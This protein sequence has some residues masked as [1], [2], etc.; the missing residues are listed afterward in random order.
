MNNT[1]GLSGLQVVMIASVIL[2]VMLIKLS[3]YVISL[4]VKHKIAIGDD[5]NSDMRLA[6]RA[7]ANF[8][9]YTPIALILL[10]LLTF[11]DAHVEVIALLAITFIIGRLLH[12]HGLLVGEKQE[13]PFRR[14]RFI[15]MVFTFLSL[16]LMALAMLIY[17]F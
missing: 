15:G 12:I 13:P 1:I 8:T 10:L 17:L 6:I 11:A 7:Q 5:D 14:F 3:A 16:G 2:V 4:R 9:E